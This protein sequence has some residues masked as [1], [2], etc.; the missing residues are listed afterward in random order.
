MCDIPIGR[1][2]TGGSAVWD[3][4]REW[5]YP[6]KNC[7]NLCENSSKEIKFEL[8]GSF[9]GALELGNSGNGVTKIRQISW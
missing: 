9:R 4:Y 3:L 1:D 2:D 8:N 6:R 5:L 7:Q